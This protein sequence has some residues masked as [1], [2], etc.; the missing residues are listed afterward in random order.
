M[1]IMMLTDLYPPVIGGLEIHVRN[2]SAGLVALGHS[3]AVVTLAQPEAPAF[4]VDER[5]VRIYRISGTMQRAAGLF[6]DAGRRFAPPFPDPEALLAIKR[7]IAAEQPTIIHAHNWLVH[8]LLPLKRWSTAKLVVSM[9]DY[10]LACARKDLTYRGAPCDGP[11]FSKC[12]R[13]GAAHYGTL[14]GYG[15]VLTHRVASAA[16]RALVDCFLPVSDA[17][18]VG[19]GLTTGRQRY[20]VVPNFLPDDAATAQQSAAEFLTQLP[21]GPFLLFVG[22]LIPAKGIDV[23]LDAY[24]GLTDAPPLVLIGATWPGSPTTFPPNVTT[25]R[26]WPHH[27]VMAA[28]RR[29]TIGLV[30]SIWGEPCPTVALEVMAAGKPLIASRIGGLTTI[31]AENETGLLVPPGDV[32]AWRTAIR[33]LLADPDRAA[34]LGAAGRARVHQRFVA[35]AVIPQIAGVYQQFLNTPTVREAPAPAM[36][37]QLPQ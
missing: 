13:C 12:L 34:R 4:E 6:S 2:L 37:G 30:P 36:G 17:V 26:D 7:I 20:Q 29:S 18:A 33:T 25:L 11:S 10:S 21:A 15:T 1:Q 23:L 31:V 22:A 32:A 24:A 14:K 3:V 16:E 27:A 5:G 8:S 9:H 35:S 19:N 28:W